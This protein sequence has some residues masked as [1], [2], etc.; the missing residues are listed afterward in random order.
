MV[1]VTFSM[2]GKASSQGMYMWNIK[3]LSQTYQKLWSRLVF[4]Y[5]GQRSWSMSLG[6]KFGMDGKASPQ[7]KYMWNMKALPQT[8]QKL[9]PR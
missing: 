8:G 1:K 4:R 5:V 7:G 3:A 2:D 6:Q 9:L